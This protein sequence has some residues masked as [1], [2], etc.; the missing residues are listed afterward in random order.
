MVD[1]E[2]ILKID[3]DWEPFVRI[4]I[5][6]QD[7]LAYCDIGSMVSTM[8]KVIYDSLQL[9]MEF[10]SSYHEHA[11]GDISEIR[12]KVKD[13]LVTFSKRS[14]TVDFFIMKPNQGSIVLEG[15]SSEP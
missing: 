7:F 1:K 15:T 2:I 4:S 14:A 3:D 12:G 6:N 10:F 8:P 13:V 9:D 5:S 11:N